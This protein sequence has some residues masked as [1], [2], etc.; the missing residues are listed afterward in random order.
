M[1]DLFFDHKILFGILA[2]LFITL[3]PLAGNIWKLF[4][5][6]PLVPWIKSKLLKDKFPTFSPYWLT[7]AVGLV[8]LF[9]LIF[10]QRSGA[11][12]TPVFDRFQI[13]NPIAEY[14]D[15]FKTNSTAEGFFEKGNEAFERG[16]AAYTLELYRRA[17][18]MNNTTSWEW[19]Q[20]VLFAAQYANNPTESGRLEFE[21]SI[22]HQLENVLSGNDYYGTRPGFVGKLIETYYWVKP[23]LPLSEREF[24]D[25]RPNG[26]IEKAVQHKNVLEAAAH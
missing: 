23:H 18:S 21:K 5:N 6:E 3:P 17:K 8:M 25:S 26:V 24:L 2:F 22:N 19:H 7:T 1:P 14:E 16:A 10:T 20:P 15:F 13:L 11:K 4:S 9:Y 12:L